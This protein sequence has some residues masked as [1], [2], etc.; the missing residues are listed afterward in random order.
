MTFR[1]RRKP[2]D[3]QG[4]YVVDLPRGGTVKS[5]W[6]IF[7]SE[8]EIFAWR[9]RNVVDG[10]LSGVTITLRIL[11]PRFPID[12]V[13]IHLREEI[14]LAKLRFD[15]LWMEGCEQGKAAIEVILWGQ[16]GA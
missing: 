4:R 5:K 11:L 6:P 10:P 3:Q 14:F 8:A 7:I 13:C 2:R 16:S 1:K 12:R 15:A 9:T